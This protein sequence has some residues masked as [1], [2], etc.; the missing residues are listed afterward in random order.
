MTLYLRQNFEYF[1]NT[2]AEELSSKVL[3]ETMELVNHFIRPIADMFSAALTILSILI[4]LFILKPTVALIVFSVF[5]SFYGI[6]LFS[7]KIYLEKQGLKR[8]QANLFRYT[9]VNEAFRAIKYIKFRSKEKNYITSYS[10]AAHT[11]ADAFAKIQFVAQVPHYALHM[12][13]FSLLI[14]AIIHLLLG[15]ESSTQNGLLEVLPTLGLFAFAGQRILPEIS[16]MYSARSLMLGTRHSAKLL[17]EDILK[18]TDNSK[19]TSW[20]LQ[21]FNEFYELVLSDV[22]YQ[23]HNTERLA[24]EKISLKI[25][26]GEKIGIVGRS[27]SGKSTLVDVILGLRQSTSGEIYVNGEELDEYLVEAWKEKIGYVPQDVRLIEGSI[28]DNIMF[29]DPIDHSRLSYGIKSANIDGISEYEDIFVN[30]ELKSL[31]RNLSGGQKQRVAAA[32]ALYN[33][34]E[35]LIFDE[36]TSSLDNITQQYHINLIENFQK[37]KTVLIVAHRLKNV[38]S[39]DRIIVMKD[40]KIVEDDVPQRLKGENLEFQKLL[41]GEM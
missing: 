17:S 22:S 29:Y 2:S 16:K 3:S 39:L 20:Q 1:E 21:T 35:I 15:A 8:T 25:K 38:M 31:A 33:N 11:M 24:L 41:K 6:I 28:A 18:L 34:P 7:S 23:Y 30:K 37:E 27:G 10:N 9:I 26:R 40:G 32:R 4:L 19:D 13:G 36:A 14:V 5:G 12:M